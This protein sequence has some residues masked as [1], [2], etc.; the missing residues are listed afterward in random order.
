M[1]SGRL[2]NGK[3]QLQ[4]E[5][6]IGGFSPYAV[7][8]HI[9][10]A[11]KELEAIDLPEMQEEVSR[12]VTRLKELSANLANTPEKVD[13][14][15]ADIEKLLERAMRTNWDPVH[16][17]MIEKEVAGHLRAYKAE[18][19]PAAYKSTFDL[20]LNKRL[21]GK[22]LVFRDWGCFICSNEEVCSSF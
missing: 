15:L 21:R 6:D 9:Q 2:R 7:K 22:K 1:P 19:E 4:N 20:M 8:V 12:A 17:K 11:I 18:M 5:Q 13:S 3:F 16:L 14:T 10:S